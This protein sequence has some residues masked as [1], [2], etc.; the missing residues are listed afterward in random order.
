MARARLVKMLVMFLT[1]KWPL[2]RALQQQICMHTV[3][4]G[5]LD[6]KPRGD[7]FL[8]SAQHADGAM[9]VSCAAG[10]ARQSDLVRMIYE[11]H[12]MAAAHLLESS[13]MSPPLQGKRSE[14]ALS[15][16]EEFQSKYTKEINFLLKRFHLFGE[17]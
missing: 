1:L 13:Q 3:R 2:I 17:K 15:D 9:R 12:F 7:Q 6:R 14:L 10:T 5:P 16:E 11:V 8:E 4:S